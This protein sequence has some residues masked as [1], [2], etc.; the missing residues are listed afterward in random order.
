M[1]NLP[2]WPLATGY[3]PALAVLCTDLCQQWSPREV[4]IGHRQRYKR[5]S[6]VLGKS[7][8][9]HLVES[10]QPLDDAEHMLDSGSHS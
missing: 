8:V 3:S 7:A 6:R 4:D 10:P 1:A 9:A 2:M 5:A